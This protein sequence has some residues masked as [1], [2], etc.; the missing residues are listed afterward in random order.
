MNRNREKF[1]ARVLIIPVAVVAAFCIGTAAHAQKI[2]L[3]PNNATGDA[4][5]KA[6]TIINK[7]GSYVLS[8]NIVVNKNNVDALDITASNVTLDLQGYT[9]MVATGFSPNNGINA[10]GQSNVIIQNGIITGFTNG[11]A[12]LAGQTSTVA[13][14]TATG[15]GTGITCG[16]ACLAQD[17]T[18]QGN[19]GEGL[20]FNDTT[21][22]Y[23]N[24]ILQGN[25]Q[26]TGGGPAGQVTG[27]TS[28]GHNLCNGV[29][30]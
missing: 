27:G 21:G 26:T 1:S 7:S 23:L 11:A 3:E 24:D 4:A 13:G 6:L 29:V 15:N 28:L 17:D 9:I 25:S 16:I 30:C 20:I 10:T 5:A 18:V 2:R 12:V 22:G 19:T 8:K 14:I